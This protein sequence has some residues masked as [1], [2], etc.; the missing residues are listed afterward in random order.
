[1]KHAALALSA[2]AVSAFGCGSSGGSC[3]APENPTCPA[4][5]PSFAGAVFPDVIG[6]YCASCH[7][8]SGVDT[9]TELVTYD[10]IYGKNGSEAAEIYNQVFE[11]C[12][13]PPAGSPALPAADR[14]QL[15]DWLACGAPNN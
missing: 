4:T 7:S 15:L 1:M 2:L 13:M 9:G 10:E 12:L 5:P 11:S 6:P 14:Q 8:P 3:T